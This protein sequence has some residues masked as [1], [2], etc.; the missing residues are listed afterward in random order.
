MAVNINIPKPVIDYNDLDNKPN[1][2]T[3]HSELTLNDGTNPHGTTASDVGAL[4]MPT[5]TTSQY[6]RGDGSLETFPTIPDVSGKQDVPIVVSSNITA[7]NDRVY[8]VVANAT[9]TDPTPAE[10]KGFTVFVR[11]GTATLGSSNFGV[12]GCVIRRIFHS[13]SWT[14]SFHQ[15]SLFST[16]LD[17]SVANKSTNVN[18]DQASNTRYPSVKAL[19]DWAT[20]LFVPTTRTINGL[21]L[22]ANRTLTASDV[23]A[24][25]GSGSSTGT[26]TG[27]E[28]ESSLLTKLGVTKLKVTGDQ[29]T[30][31]T[32]AVDITDLVSGTLAAGKYAINGSIRIG[33]N[34]TTGVSI[35]IT[36]PSGAT[37][38]IHV[39]GRGSTNANNARETLTTSGTLSS[40]NF[41]QVNGDTVIDLFGTITIG[42]TPGVVQFIFAK[43]TS[44]TATIFDEGTQIKLEKW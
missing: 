18:T 24:P 16:A 9:F 28:T 34:S 26:N 27:D 44:G 39:V 7:Q 20:A 23:G 15:Q 4:P 3:E 32:T 10:G 40:S 37:M 38:A 17:E 22:S 19:F 2:V 31:S 13:G 8:H 11:N 12:Q 14:N 35:G 25:S 42:A 6:L 29:S 21:D 33:S 30:T 36:I 5:G 41:A 1:L 43:V